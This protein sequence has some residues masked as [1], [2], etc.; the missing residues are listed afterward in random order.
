MNAPRRYAP[1]LPPIDRPDRYRPHHPPVYC[2][3]C[4]ACG[5]T[6]VYAADAV[7]GETRELEEDGNGHTIVFAGEAVA[8][9]AT[10]YTGSY[11][12]FVG[13]DPV[14]CNIARL[15]RKYREAECGTDA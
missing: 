8:A 14:F 6:V 11:T 10:R 5:T 7:T 1:H 15:R 2:K 9:A 13:H 4:P 3:T 12:R